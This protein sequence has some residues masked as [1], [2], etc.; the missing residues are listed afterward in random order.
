MAAPPAPASGALLDARLAAIEAQLV[1]IAAAVG[2]PG[3]P[4]AAAD[5]ARA[6]AR[7]ANAVVSD[8]PLIV[9]TRA[10]GGTPAAW[11]AGFNRAALFALP[12]AAAD[13]LLL[14]YALPGG[15]ALDTRRMRLAHHIGALA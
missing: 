6:A 2:V 4:G 14:D 15:G 8:A 12:G 10:G 1:L 13:A 11:P 7:R 5:Q 9:V 3:A